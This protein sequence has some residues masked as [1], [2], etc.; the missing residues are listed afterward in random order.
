M[1]I[2]SIETSC[3]ETAIAI[4]DAQEA[5]DRTVTFNV[6]GNAIL[7]QID[8]HQQYGGVFP[9][10]A[11]REHAKNLV[12][13]LRAILEEAEMLHLNAVPIE[14]DLRAKLE[15]TLEREPGLADLLLDFLDELDRPAI[16][17]I[18]VTNGPGLEPALWVGVN[19]AKALSEAWSIPVLP[20]NHMEG[21]VFSALAEESDTRQYSVPPLEFPMLALLVSGGH[22]EL[23]LV[24]EGFSYE[25][26]GQTR[27][28][29]VGEAYDKVAR[30]MGLPYPGGPEIDKLAK[31]GKAKGESRFS[32]PRPMLAS[33]DC[34]FSL[35]GLK[36]A[37]MYELKDK[38]LTDEEKEDAAQEFEDAVTEVLVKKTKKAIDEHMP[39]ALLIGGGVSANRHI[40]ESLQEMLNE[41]YPNIQ[42]FMPGKGL[43]GDNALMIAFAAY[44]RNKEQPEAVPL[45]SI[46][47]QGNIRI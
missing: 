43:F 5:T 39:T 27:D 36:T 37:V 16:D 14:N 35:S 42:F 47:A 22:T 25:A 28:D 6:L 3:D 15:A 31:A 2:L 33:G 32:F 46:T 24:Q 29:A 20:I 44:Y 9:A 4:V 38:D 10:L 40:R 8:I 18:A 30:L 26:V 19:F 45:E 1:R 23:D 13:I 21:H 34:D 17:L 12:P 7:S 41:H 11:K